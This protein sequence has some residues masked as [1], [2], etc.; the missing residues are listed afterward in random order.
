MKLKGKTD[1]V[2]HARTFKSERQLGCSRKKWFCLVN[3]WEGQ[4][5]VV[6][7]GRIFDTTT[8]PIDSLPA[9]ASLGEGAG[10]FRDGGGI[11]MRPS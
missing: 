5:V 6:L 8:M 10:D 7:K 9:R 1:F 2:E 4:R 3:R 11:Q